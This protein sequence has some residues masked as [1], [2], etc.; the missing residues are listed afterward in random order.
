MS[1]LPL[2]SVPFTPPPGS[3]RIGV[4]STLQWDMSGIDIHTKHDIGQQIS[5]LARTIFS[6]SGDSDRVPVASGIP[7]GS[8]MPSSSR[9]SHLD[10]PLDPPLNIMEKNLGKQGRRVHQMKY[11]CVH[12]ILLTIAYF[13]STCVCLLMQAKRWRN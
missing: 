11:A 13:I 3:N 8:L 1:L 2:T 7:P 9:L 6:V 10:S 4:V 5:S 12:L